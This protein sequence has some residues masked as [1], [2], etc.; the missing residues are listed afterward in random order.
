ML[1]RHLFGLIVSSQLEEYSELPTFDCL[2][3]GHP[4]ILDDGMYAINVWIAIVIEMLNQYGA[5][6]QP[7][8]IACLRP[9]SCLSAKSRLII[10][11]LYYQYY[12]T[13]ESTSLS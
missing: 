9:I 11:S 7:W 8:E 2:L 1:L 10:K 4:I 3:L 13:M 5:P 6:F 12:T